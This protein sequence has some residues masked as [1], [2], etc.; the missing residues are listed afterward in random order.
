[1][2]WNFVSAIFTE[3]KELTEKD[4]DTIERELYRDLYEK[5][6]RIQMAVEYQQIMDTAQIDNYLL[7][8]TQ[9]PAARTAAT[10]GAKLR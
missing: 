4:R 9:S 10:G 8:T 6:L 5:K 3:P 2:L 1:M 7:N